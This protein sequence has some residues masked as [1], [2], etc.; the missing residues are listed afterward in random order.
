MF[1]YTSKNCPLL[2]VLSSLSKSNS[3]LCFPKVVSRCASELYP[4]FS[5]SESHHICLFTLLHHSSLPLL[6][7]SIYNSSRVSKIQL[8]LL[9]I[10]F[11]LPLTNILFR[12]AP[13]YLTSSTSLWEVYPLAS[14][15]WILVQQAY[16][17]CC[18]KYHCHFLNC[19]SS[20]PYLLSLALCL[21]DM[22]TQFV[23]FTC[24]CFNNLLWEDIC[25][26]SEFFFLF[27]WSGYFSIS[28]LSTPQQSHPCLYHC[29]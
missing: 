26:D 13:P 9:V 24:Y 18:F 10:P 5:P 23:L 22:V 3:F 14:W 19:Q 20:S 27:P 28:G 12:E 4:L 7:H 21:L 25:C 17:N 29:Q 15:I 2:S 16:W 1:L 8:S 11:L 6:I